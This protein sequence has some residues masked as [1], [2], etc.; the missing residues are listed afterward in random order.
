MGRALSVKTG[1][2][3]R[4][5]REIASL[6]PRKNIAK[7]LPYNPLTFF[8]DFA[9]AELQSVCPHGKTYVDR[10]STQHTSIHSCP[11]CTAPGSPFFEDA[12]LQCRECKGLFRPPHDFPSA[13]EEKARYEEHLNDVQDERFQAFVRP[14]T[15]KVQRDFTP[16]D[17]G[18]DFG[19]GIAPIVRHVLTESGYTIEA[20]DPFF[21]PHPERL[22]RSY[23][24]I[25]C[26]EVI[27][28]FHHPAREFERLK[29]MLKPGGKLYCMTMLHH[30]GIDFQN[31]HYRRDDT[32]VFIY[33][34]E[35]VEW[36][37]ERFGF[38]DVS[39]EGRLIVWSA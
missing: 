32:H 12:W 7:S 6:Q 27:E 9:Q 34:R 17:K 31:W 5:Q 35:T 29:A 36:I 21:A 37:T 1:D 11:L 38:A 28:H 22:D 3:Y 20:Y 26:C 10:M 23:D 15:A 24:Y 33:Q 16:A 2:S 25:T 19:S 8:S 39:I 13:S 14:I 18:L 30:D 4:K